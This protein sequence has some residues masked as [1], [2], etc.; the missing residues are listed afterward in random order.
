MIEEYIGGSI[1]KT[2]KSD[3][4]VTPNLDECL[5]CSVSQIESNS[6]RDIDYKIPLISLVD[7]EIKQCPACKII[8]ILKDPTK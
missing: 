1:F 2:I 5:F 6:I 3:V 4:R 7:D 8:Y